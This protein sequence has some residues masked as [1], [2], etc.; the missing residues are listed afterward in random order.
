MVN[1]EQYA[2]VWGLPPT[3][4]G[5]KEQWIENSPKSITGCE[6]L[7]SP[8]GNV[9]YNG[10][11]HGPEGAPGDVPEML[12]GPFSGTSIAPISA[13]WS[14]RRLNAAPFHLQEKRRSPRHNAVQAAGLE[15]ARVE[16]RPD[17]L[18]VVVPRNT[19]EGGTLVG[20]NE[21]DELL[22]GNAPAEVR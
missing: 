9:S 5:S 22:N 3:H 4:K 2:A 19:N 17:G 18:I 12:E 14:I 6:A 20:G 10:E 16:V 1:N 8:P 15:V 7:R 13:I 11:G 21:W